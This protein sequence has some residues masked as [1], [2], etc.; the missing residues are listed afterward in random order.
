M[1]VNR[2][3][4]IG[5]GDPKIQHHPICFYALDNTLHILHMTDLNGGFLPCRTNKNKNKMRKS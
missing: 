3:K 2:S 5:G 1:K 4:S